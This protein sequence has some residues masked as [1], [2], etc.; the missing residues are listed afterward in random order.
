MPLRIINSTSTRKHT[1]MSWQ[2]NIFTLSLGQAENHALNGLALPETGLIIRFVGISTAKIGHWGGKGSWERK[3]QRGWVKWSDFSG[4]FR[5]GKQQSSITISRETWWTWDSVGS[6]HPLSSWKKIRV[7]AMQP[8]WEK[9]CVLAL[10]V[11]R[12]GNQ[13]VGWSQGT[14]SSLSYSDKR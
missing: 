4:N 5:E 14:E 13:A 1:N 9:H 11:I 2:T 8:V 7:M 10:S 12:R 3:L 6:S